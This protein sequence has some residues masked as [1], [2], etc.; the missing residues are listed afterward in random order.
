M[1]VFNYTF[2]QK[3]KSTQTKFFKPSTVFYIEQ[4]NYFEDQKG[5]QQI[6]KVFEQKL[7]KN[8]KN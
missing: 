4:K 8:V 6:L 7:K 3:D 2:N 1:N 5:E